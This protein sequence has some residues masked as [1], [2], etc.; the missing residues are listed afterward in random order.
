MAKTMFF[1]FLTLTLLAVACARF[2][3]A[4]EWESWKA[5]YK[6]EFPDRHSDHRRR[7]IFESNMRFIEGHNSN[8]KL[9]GY[10]LGMNAYGHLVR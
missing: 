1:A 9:H 4:D 7:G 8:A 3:D 6:M 2:Q 5:K 10:T